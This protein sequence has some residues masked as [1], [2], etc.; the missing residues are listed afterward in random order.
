MKSLF[1][2]END[3]LFSPIGMVTMIILSIIMILLEI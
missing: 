3:S 2:D 1:E